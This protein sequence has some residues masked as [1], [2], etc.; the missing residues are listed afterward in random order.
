MLTWL[1]LADEASGDVDASSTGGADVGVCRALV[2]VLALVRDADLP[3]AFRTDAH[4]RS[5]DVLA[6]VATVVGL[7]LA[8][9]EVHAVPAVGGQGVAVGA[10]AAEGPG[11]V[12][13]PG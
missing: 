10:D 3:V 9:V 4:E 2:D 7:G 1:A 12:V 11:N 5:D 8:L 6:I 13:A